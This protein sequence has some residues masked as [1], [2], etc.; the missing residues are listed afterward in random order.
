MKKIILILCMLIASGKINCQSFSVF[1][2][3]LSNFSEV[4]AQFYVFDA[5]GYQITNLGISDFTVYEN[6]IKR[7]VIDVNCPPNI[8]NSL[9]SVLVMDVSSSMCTTYRLKIAMA[10]AN[11]WIDLLNL[12]ESECALT[13]FSKNSYINQDFTSNRGTLKYAVNS[14]ACVTTTNYDEAFLNELAGAIPIAKNGKYRRVIIFLTDG[15]P[16]FEPQTDKII[17]EA[18]ENNITI[19]GVAVAMQAPDCM[20]KMAAETGGECFENIIS[21]DE[22]Q[23]CYEKILVNLKNIAPCE[24][25]WQSDYPCALEKRNVEVM[26]Q[27]S[28][29]K[30]DYEVTDNMTTGLQFTPQTIYCQNKP[31]GVTFDTI[32]NVSSLNRDINVTDIISNNPSYSISPRS[33]QLLAGQSINLHLQYKPSDSSYNTAT[34]SFIPNICE[35]LYYASGGFDG[36]KSNIKTLVLTRPNGGEVYVAGSDTLITWKGISPYDTVNLEL[37]IDSG[38]TWQTIT[39]KTNGLYYSWHVPKTPSGK[40]LVRVNQLSNNYSK[41]DSV[42]TINAAKEGVNSLAWSPDGKYIALGSFSKCQIW[43]PYTGQLVFNLENVPANTNSLTWSPDG[44]YL[45]ALS[46]EFKVLFW[47]PATGK[48][49]QTL[50]DDNIRIYDICWSPSGKNFATY[51]NDRTIRVWEAGTFKIL[52]E[53]Q[54]NNVGFLDFTWVDSDKIL[55]LNESSKTTTF[56]ALTGVVDKSILLDEN[57]KKV[58]WNNDR[59]SIA[60]ISDKPSVHIWNPVD[61]SSVRTLQNS[62]L[63]IVDEIVWHPDNIRIATSSKNQSTI[64]WNTKTGQMLYQLSSAS[65]ISLVSSFSPDGL[66]LA[67]RVRNK[68]VSIWDA[69]NGIV[70]KNLIGHTSEIIDAEWS[71]DSRYIA[72]SSYDNTVKIWDLNGIQSVQSD[73]SDAVFSIVMPEMTARD[74]DMGQCVVGQNKDSIVNNF[75]FNT[76]SYKCRIDSVYFTGSD[77]SAFKLVNGVPPFYVDSKALEKAEFLFTPYKLGTHYAKIVIITQTD[78]LKRNITGVGIEEAIKVENN[79]IDFGLV[80]V[81]EY[82]DTLQAITIK[83]ISAK[84]VQITQTKH[85]YPND[86]DF[87]TLSGGGSFILQPGEVHKMDLRFA[88]SKAGRTNG[89]LD[90]YFNGPGSPAEVQLFGTGQET[91]SLVTSRLD[92]IPPLQCGLSTEGKLTLLNKGDDSATINEIHL[93]SVDIQ[94]FEFIAPKTPFIIAPQ[95]SQELKIIFK[96]KTLGSK[97][98]GIEIRTSNKANLLSIF[99]IYVYGQKDSID[100]SFVENVI[101]VGNLCPGQ[102]ADTSI[103]IINNG[104]IAT[105]GYFT[106]NSDISIDNKDI[107]LESGQLATIPIKFKG[108]LQKGPFDETIGITDK[109]CGHTKNIRIIGNII[110]PYLQAKGIEITGQLNKPAQNKLVIINTGMEDVIINNIENITSP[111][112]LID[113]T[114]PKYIKSGDSLEL[115]IGFLSDDTE[116]HQLTARILGEPCSLTKDVLFT[117][118]AFMDIAH[119]IIQAG[120]ASA[121]SGDT[122]E[123]PITLSDTS[124]FAETGIKSINFQLSYNPTLLEPLNYYNKIINDKTALINFDS[125]QINLPELANIKFIS[126][127]GNSET[128]ALSILNVS[129]NGGT[130]DFE[131]RDGEFTLLG[132]CP[133]GGLRL[134]NPNDTMTF[135]V[136]PNPS[137]GI[138]NI[139]LNLTESGRATLTLTDL[140]GKELKTLFDK[141]I[142]VYGK[143]SVILSTNNLNSGKYFLILKTPTLIKSGKIEVLK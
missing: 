73:V 22:A 81:G 34:F 80:K 40:C 110:E 27:N 115:E 137:S 47:N 106:Y 105:Q 74:V 11:R 133:E 52:S 29:S 13:S 112:E 45:S 127:L 53:Y 63:S 111:F 9:S 119:G 30:L 1:N 65:D 6:G 132:I 12:G 39:D 16:N 44:K 138:I 113:D 50:G 60:S 88:A 135:D 33:F 99:T 5:T 120:S 92:E 117:G 7:D 94:D 64:I 128:S 51:C 58:L 83:N 102:G 89:I 19:Y 69:N 41:N 67:V 143:Y 125:I 31:V 72:T 70:L 84:P 75:F 62:A 87:S 56:N 104:T 57:T 93:L 4:K 10:A 97:G 131:A 100:L 136:K 90:F 43:N 116:K 32:L 55:A 109:T 76:G 85:N 15:L 28:I 48:L 91:K 122:V 108:L 54:I 25:T 98:L 49:I 36:K 129:S 121:Y 35:P 20:K 141:E 140:T 23:K 86:V 21:A 124:N 42:V 130:S 24:I 79:I 78:T 66:E 14:L 8:S 59:S 96:P 38:K 3:D 77:A 17:Q 26:W 95:D 118:Q 18:K 114:F 103:T 139:D 142:N 71:P 101:D 61:G 2:P 126:G 68:T 46:N 107:S 123:I 37:S 82:K 134:I